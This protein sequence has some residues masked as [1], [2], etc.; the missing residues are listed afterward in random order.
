M[1]DPLEEKRKKKY[2]LYS[3]LASFSLNSGVYKE[4]EAASNKWRCQARRR[5]PS[6]LT[7]IPS[8]VDWPQFG[9]Q[10]APR[11]ITRTEMVVAG[12]SQGTSKHKI[13]E[14]EGI[15]GSRRAPCR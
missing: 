12:S 8:R 14:R 5:G 15:R 2:S 9:T 11:S 3:L 7:I 13:D 4:L 6:E 1:Q 10:E